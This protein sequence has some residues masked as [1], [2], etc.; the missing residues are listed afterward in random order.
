MVESV[1]EMSYEIEVLGESN[2]AERHREYAADAFSQPHPV[3][4]SKAVRL[5]TDCSGR[6]N[7]Y[8]NVHLQ[9]YDRKP[10][11]RPGDRVG[12]EEVIRGLG[13]TD[14]E[15]C[16][17]RIR[18]PEPENRC[19]NECIHRWNGKS[20]QGSGYSYRRMDSGA[21]H[22]AQFMHSYV[23]AAMVFVPSRKGKSHCEEEF[24]PL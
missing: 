11:E 7:V 23:P 5:I 2:H 21:G 24:A 8:P 1:S 15:G 13:A 17:I 19:F 20:D 10:R 6:F 18:K 16:E 4:G 22:D 12:V 3:G 14:T 9:A